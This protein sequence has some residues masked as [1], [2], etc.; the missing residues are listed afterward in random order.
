MVHIEGGMHN[1]TCVKGGP[2]YYQAFLKFVQHQLDITTLKLVYSND[3]VSPAGAA[4]Q[5]Q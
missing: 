2:R 3:V 4:S 1:D 5:E